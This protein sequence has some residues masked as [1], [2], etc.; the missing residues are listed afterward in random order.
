MYFTFKKK[1]HLAIVFFPYESDW[2]QPSAIQCIFPWLPP[3]S[4]WLSGLRSLRRTQLQVRSNWYGWIWKLWS[5]KWISTRCLWPRETR[6]QDSSNNTQ[7]EAFTRWPSLSHGHC[8]IGGGLMLET[9]RCDSRVLKGD[10]SIQWSK[11]WKTENLV[12]GHVI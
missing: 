4:H 9:W 8:G 5:S 7:I 12:Q 10:V 11:D 3:Y 2:S 6:C 1:W